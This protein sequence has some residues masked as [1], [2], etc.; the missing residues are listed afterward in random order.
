MT[1]TACQVHVL[2]ALAFLATTMAIQPLLFSVMALTVLQIQTV[3]P[4]PAYREC[5]PL[6]TIKWLVSIAMDLLAL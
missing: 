3:P 1:M 5:A 2:L 4:T 6:A